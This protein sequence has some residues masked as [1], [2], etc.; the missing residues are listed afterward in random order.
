MKKVL[1]AVGVIVLL[2]I[3]VFLPAMG[4]SRIDYPAMLMVDDILYVDTFTPV[5]NV[6]KGD[7]LGYTKSYTKTEPRRNGQANFEKGTPYAAAGEGLAVRIA[8]Q[9]ILFKRYEHEG[10]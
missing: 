7:I 6:Q 10:T 1:A 8:D 2:A 9:W 3:L 5:T 4:G